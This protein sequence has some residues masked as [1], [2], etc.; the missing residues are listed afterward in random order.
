MKRGSNTTLLVAQA[1][2]SLACGFHFSTAENPAR[3]VFTGR[4]HVIGVIGARVVSIIPAFYI[5]GG[6][7]R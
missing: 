2:G 7:K 1:M 4:E 3:A 5:G 6:G